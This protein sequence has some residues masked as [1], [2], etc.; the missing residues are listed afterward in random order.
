MDFG[1]EPAV[2]SLAGGKTCKGGAQR[3][4]EA[5]PF[6]NRE[7]TAYLLEDDVLAI[8]GVVDLPAV[9]H[10]AGIRVDAALAGVRVAGRDDH[11]DAGAGEALPRAVVRAGR[12]VES[13]EAQHDEGQSDETELEHR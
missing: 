11:L 8:R 4:G 5:D 2:E 3:A 6:K 7:K 9:G 1:R 13:Q 12:P 10:H